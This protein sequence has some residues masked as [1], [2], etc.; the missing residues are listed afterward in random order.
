MHDYSIDNHPKEKILFGLAFIAITAAPIL[1][2]AV[3]A[4]LAA[5]EALA[6]I[7]AAPVT[8]I[9]VFSVFVGIYQPFNR[10]LWKWAWVRKFLLVPDL[11]GE[12]VCKG[13][14]KLKN[15]EKA[16]SQWEGKIV[17]TQSWGKKSRSSSNK[18]I[19]FEKRVSEYF[20]R[21]RGRIQAAVFVQKR[22]HCSSVGLEQARWICRK[23]FS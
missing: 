6:G 7:P 8:A 10:K 3:N 22:S 14:T 9:P 1:N 17:V 5:V 19:L 23:S 2:V 12:W 20:S 4:G 15:G 11:N 13:E 18:G 16:D 21:Q